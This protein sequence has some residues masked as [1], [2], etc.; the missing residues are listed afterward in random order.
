MTHVTLI[1]LD[2]GLSGLPSIFRFDELNNALQIM[3]CTN[4]VNVC[5]GKQTK[6]MG[7]AWGGRYVAVEAKAVIAVRVFHARLVYKIVFVD[8]IFGTGKSVCFLE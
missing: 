6:E 5:I 4:R 7:F 1:T 2:N 3:H 8:A